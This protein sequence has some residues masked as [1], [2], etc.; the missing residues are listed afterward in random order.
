LKNEEAK[1]DFE[2]LIY[3]FRDWLN[4][5]ENEDFVTRNEKS[6]NLTT[7]ETESEWLYDEGDDAG[8]KEYQRRGYELQTSF[9]KFRTRKN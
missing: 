9:T 8:F 2:T 4:D 1:N 5:G 3:G 7:L 6:E